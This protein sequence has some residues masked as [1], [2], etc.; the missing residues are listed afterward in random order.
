MTLIFIDD[1]NQELNANYEEAL[2]IVKT[3]LAA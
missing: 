2:M 3:F 1:V